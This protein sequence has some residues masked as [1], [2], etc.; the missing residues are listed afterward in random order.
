MSLSFFV[1]GVEQ[2]HQLCVGWNIMTGKKFISI[3][4]IVHAKW[5]TFETLVNVKEEFSEAKKIRRAENIVEK[6]IYA[7][8]MMNIGHEGEYSDR[9]PENS[10]L[11]ISN[12]NQ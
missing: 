7:K 4:C 12:K 1:C 8:M 10:Q 6:R 2:H 9:K 11:H 3:R 5:K